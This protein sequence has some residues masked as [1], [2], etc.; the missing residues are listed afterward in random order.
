[1][2]L[3]K[4]NN[5]LTIPESQ[6]ASVMLV[7]AG[8]DTTSNSMT[9]IAFLLAK[10]PKIQERLFQELEKAMPDRKSTLRLALLPIASHNHKIYATPYSSCFVTGIG[11]QRRTSCHICGLSSWKLLA[12]TLLYLEVYLESLQREA[13]LSADDSFLKG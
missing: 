5:Y 11:M 13:R 12:C 9:F 4:K 1:M 7:V 2:E 10:H 6:V 8:T 3:E